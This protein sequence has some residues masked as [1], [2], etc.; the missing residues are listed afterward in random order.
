[1]FWC[2]IWTLVRS[3]IT[4]LEMCGQNRLAKL[5]RIRR[6]S[7][8][9]SEVSLDPCSVSSTRRPSGAP[10]SLPRER[11]RKRPSSSSGAT[12]AP[13]AYRQLGF[14]QSRS[15][16]IHTSVPDECLAFF[17][18]HL[19]A[20]MSDISIRLPTIIRI[21]IDGS[22]AGNRS[23]YHRIQQCGR[24]VERTQYFENVRD[25]SVRT[26]GFVVDGTHTLDV[27][28][29]GADEKIDVVVADV[30]NWRRWKNRCCGC[31]CMES[32]AVT[33]AVAADRDNLG[34][35]VTKLDNES[36]YSFEEHC[37]MSDWFAVHEA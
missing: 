36:K 6:S 15:R 11:R 17:N 16:R 31:R 14:P 4:R 22:L 23:T 28:T 25:E 30:W 7:S 26:R 5:C 24:H 18:D 2:R 12:V 32:L 34:Q 13:K 20:A 33:I 19:S 27:Y 21:P 29:D 3:V 37:D 1:M 35:R 8:L 9:S 10:A